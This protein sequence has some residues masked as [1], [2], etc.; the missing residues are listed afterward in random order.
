[1]L[2]DSEPPKPWTVPKLEVTETLI[3]VF[4]IMIGG[5]IMGLNL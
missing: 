1:L 3:G 5:M 2:R 4:V